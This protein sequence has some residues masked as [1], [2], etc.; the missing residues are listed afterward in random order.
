[1]CARVLTRPCRASAPK[2]T[3]PADPR[4]TSSSPQ[5]GQCAV[6]SVYHISAEAARRMDKVPTCVER[7]ESRLVDFHS[8]NSSRSQ[9]LTLN[10][11]PSRPTSRS[12]SS[13]RT[14]RPS[15]APWGRASPRRRT[16]PSR[17][18]RWPVIKCRWTSNS[19][20]HA[21]SSIH[22]QPHPQILDPM[23]LLVDGQPIRPS[24]IAPA[25]VRME[26]L[27]G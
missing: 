26:A 27:D 18:V 15:R 19:Y 3:G 7:I 14:L 8:S 13:T 6:L 2:A 12:T 22:P 23:T 25:H 9:I 16:G 11:Q 5:T 4:P 17:H 10:P 24:Q 1:M 20:T 21:R